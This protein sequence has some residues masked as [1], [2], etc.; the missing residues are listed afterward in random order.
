MRYNCLLIACRTSLITNPKRDLPT[1]KETLHLQLHC[2]HRKQTLG[3]PLPMQIGY[4]LNTANVSPN[5]VTLA[6]WI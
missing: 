5:P 2:A 4:R 1:L 6:S 3:C